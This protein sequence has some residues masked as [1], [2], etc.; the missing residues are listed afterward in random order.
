MYLTYSLT[1]DNRVSKWRL[2]ILSFRG[3]EKLIQNYPLEI[4]ERLV[5]IPVLNVTDI[6]LENW[7]VF[8]LIALLHL[9]IW[10]LLCPK[11]KYFNLMKIELHYLYDH[12][13]KM[14]LCN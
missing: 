11:S 14:T 7:F 4:R 8:L 2:H 9:C 12:P 13:K 5:E 3:K 1:G 6:L 10:Y